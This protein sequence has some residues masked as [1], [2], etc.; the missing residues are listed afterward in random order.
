MISSV[1][2]FQKIK[3]TTIVIMS[4]L[5]IIVGVRHFIDPIFFLKIM[6]PYIPFHIE[7]VYISGFFEVLFGFFLLFKKFRKTSA[8]GLIILLI[9][10]FP[11]NLYIYQFPEILCASKLQAFIRLCFQ[12]PLIL[13]AYWHSIEKS[14]F[15]YSLMCSLLFVPTLFYFLTLKIGC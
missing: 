10:V 9:A 6:P 5:Y 15:K 11:A 3:F 2:F 14:S 8:L 12:V 1:K 13:I 7:M 4:I